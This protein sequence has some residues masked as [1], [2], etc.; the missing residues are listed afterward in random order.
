M[1]SPVWNPSKERIEQSNMM[2]FLH[3]VQIQQPKI[4][5][6]DDLYAWSIEHSKE[7][8]PAFWGFCK[9]KSKKSGIT[10][11]LMK[12]KCLAQNGLL[13]VNLTLLKIF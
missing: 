7:F 10:S 5:N 11:L 1:P 2:K 9:V 13:A 12:I 8:W 3:H 4:N 6:Y